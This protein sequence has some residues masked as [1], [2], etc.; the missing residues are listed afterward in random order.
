MCSLLYG[1]V[2]TI[3]VSFIDDYK[4]VRNNYHILKIKSFT[5]KDYQEIGCLLVKV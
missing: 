2:K 5:E 3:I 4:N 1:Y